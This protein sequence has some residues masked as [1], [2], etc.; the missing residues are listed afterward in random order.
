M[1]IDNVKI[2][3]PFLLTL[4]AG[5]CTVLGS[6][7]SFLVKDFKK[8]YLQF[9]LGLSAG[10]MIFVSFAEILPMAVRTVGFF[11]ANLAFFGGILLVMLI[12]FIT[13][14]EYIDERIKTIDCDKKIM[15]AGI[16]TALGIAIHNLPEGVAVFV[17]SMVN[18]KLGISLA[19]AIALHNIPEGIA[20]AMPIFYATKS[21]RKA[22]WYSFLAGIVEPI[23]AIAAILILLPFLT[24]AILS[25]CFAAV[26]G[27]MV[28][29]SFDELLPLSYEEQGRHIAIFGVI[30]GMFIMFLSLA[31]L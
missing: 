28:F 6:F 17:S 29:V 25:F 18:I 10:V 12:D 14:H 9:F 31:L 23:G 20:I 11:K 3:I 24:P 13:P 5:L 2:W 8:S 27:I 30:A 7:I 21:R 22:F 1:D 16:R 26:A 4:V 19:F 15:K